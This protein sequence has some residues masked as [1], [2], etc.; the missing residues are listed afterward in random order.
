MAIPG[1]RKRKRGPIEP[2][3]PDMP[4]EA[5]EVSGSPRYSV[6][7]DNH[8]IKRP[9]RYMSRGE[10][11][12]GQAFSDFFGILPEL[13]ADANVRSMDAILAAL[14]EKM[15]ISVAE[16]APEVLADA[17]RKAAGEFLA[18]RAELISIANKQARIR[19]AHP[20][21]RF[22]LSRRKTQIIHLLNS[23]LGADTVKTVQ[24]IHG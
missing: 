22:E 11:E 13:S 9:A 14:V 5:A 19:T 18:T 20:A 8:N 24:I 2:V 4:I 12:S 23:T 21:V 1:K 3:L 17:W 10:R 16:H 15:D 6:V 7:E